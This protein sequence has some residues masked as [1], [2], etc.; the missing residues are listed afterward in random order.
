MATEM[1]ESPKCWQSKGNNSSITNAILMKRQV[2]DHTRV[3]YSQYKVHEISTIIKKKVTNVWLRR[4]K[5]MKFRQSKGKNSSIIDAALVN[6]WLEFHDNHTMVI[7]IQYKF[8]ERIIDGLGL[9]R[10]FF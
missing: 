6:Q 8:H 5:S 3:T 2:H 4:K 1:E 10:L 7:Y 9:I